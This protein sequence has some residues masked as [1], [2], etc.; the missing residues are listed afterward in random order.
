M[1]PKQIGML[2]GALALI[3]I[4]V[5]LVVRQ[6]GPGAE[7]QDPIATWVCDSCGHQAKEPLGNTSA[8]CPE[9]AEGQM[10]QRVFFKCKKCD[11]VFEA[12]QL[13]WSPMESRAQAKCKEAD[14][15]GSLLKGV[16]KEDAQLIR[17]PGGKWA[18]RDSDAGTRVAR[19]LACPNCGEAKYDKFEK[20]LDPAAK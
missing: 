9:C 6:M 13:N 7:Q 12:Y 18:W 17:R 1:P 19:R 11:E 5:V 4:A 3:A 2:V 15:S 20:V 8:D 10:V 14:Q 16:R